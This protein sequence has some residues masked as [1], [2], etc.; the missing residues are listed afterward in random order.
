MIGIYVIC[1]I[2]F[3]VSVFINCQ[4]ASSVKE[5][6]NKEETNVVKGIATCFVIFAH[7]TIQLE[8]VDGYSRFLHIFSI[9][10]GM[11]VL[12]FFFVSGY[13]LY[14]NYKTIELDITFWK[15]RLLNMYLPCV[16]IQFIFCL[17]TAVLYQEFNIWR[18]VFN[19]FFGAWFINVILVQ[20]VIFFVTGKIAKGKSAKWIILSFL[21][22]M[23]AALIF[24]RCELN[25]RWYNGLL[26][27]PFGM[28]IA[29][30]EGKILAAIK[31]KAVLLFAISI[32]LF[33][34]SGAIFTRFKG[35]AVGIDIVKPFSGM[36]LC[37][38]ICIAFSQVKFDSRIMLYIGKRSLYFYVVH[39]N[40]LTVLESVG[41]IPQITIFYMVL[42][43]T[44]PIVEIF[45]RLRLKQRNKL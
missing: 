45:Y 17:V 7:L 30:K 19:S 3:P 28:L 10:G 23:I 32:V 29:H 39:M 6:L 14:K 1:F 41:E 25:A 2:V 13:G 31:R 5:L 33:A 26:L 12:L 18:I 37:M 44:F 24:W 38:V 43:L 22:S 35:N 11:G 34:I 4:K 40:L 42:L 27:F 16:I 21:W 15:K 8:N 9:T 36:C 20:Y